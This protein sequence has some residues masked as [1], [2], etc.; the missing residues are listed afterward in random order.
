M[1]TL[2]S[3]ETRNAVLLKMAELLEKERKTIIEINKGDL[4][5]YK[6]DD[7][8]MYDRLKVNDA[9]VDEMIASVTHLASQEDPVGVERFSFKHNNGMQVYNKTASFGTV[10][11]IYE[12]RPDV[13]VEAAGIAFKSGNKILLKGGKESTNSNLKIVELWHEALKDNG[14]ST[15]WVEYL[16]FN[17]METQAFL[18]KP[19]Q[20]VDLIVPRGGERLIAFV[21]EHATCPVIISG[22]GNNFVYVHKEA[23]LDIALKV[24][25]NAK[26]AKISACNALDKVLIDANLP[27]KESFITTLISELKT[28]EVQIL[29]DENIVKFEGVE[30]IESDDIWY[31]EFLDFKIAI[32]E[33]GSTQDVIAMINKYS[34]GHSSSIIT[35]N[36]DEAKVFMEN[37]DTAAVYHNASTRFTDGGQLGLGGELAISTD[38][39][40]QRGPIGLQ[41]LVTNKWYVH[42]NGQIR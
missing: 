15:E 40:H 27:K 29:G 37:V 13:T 4:E 20:K 5:A 16:Q 1:N 31:Q 23:D 2:L 32:A 6:G 10:L 18:E 17:R 9:K 12:S 36:E 28:F 14:A 8:S 38:K 25:I 22:R 35:T 11:I 26:T 7:I 42:G 34:G 24:I 41:H 39:L 30:P 21:K 33:I 3:I 19:T